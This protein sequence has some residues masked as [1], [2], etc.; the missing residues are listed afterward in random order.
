MVWGGTA[1]CA[2]TPTR[3]GGNGRH[4]VRTGPEGH[5]AWAPSRLVGRAARPR[6]DDRAGGAERRRPPPLSKGDVGRWRHTSPFHRGISEAALC[7]PTSVLGSG[8]LCF[9]RGRAWLSRAPRRRMGRAT[10]GTHRAGRSRGTIGTQAPSYCVRGREI[11]SCGCA[12]LRRD[13]D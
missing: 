4:W 1:P 11:W 5:A 3:R 8:S 12:V 9:L 2:T 10:L 13:P 7:C 6:G